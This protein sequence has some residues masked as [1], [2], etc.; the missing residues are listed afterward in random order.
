ME[1]G[2][3]GVRFTCA[4]VYVC[5]QQAVPRGRLRQYMI[6]CP[7]DKQKTNMGKMAWLLILSPEKNVFP[8]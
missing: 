2:T 4:C 5:A 1:T 8:D 7:Q 3:T 6:Q